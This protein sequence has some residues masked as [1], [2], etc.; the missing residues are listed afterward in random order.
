MALAPDIADFYHRP[1]GMTDPGA[2]DTVLKDAPGDIPG[3]AAY[4]QNLLLH[5]HWAPVYR[6]QLGRERIDETHTRSLAGM[7]ALMQRHDGRPLAFVR[8]L[9]QRMIGNCRHFSVFGAALLR[10]AGFP[11]RARCGFAM[12]FQKD[13]GVDHWVTEYWNGEAWQMIDF[14]IDALQRAQLQLAFDPLDVPR[15]RFLIAGEA[16]QRC[17]TGAADPARFGILD[18]NGLWFVAGNVVR[19]FAALNNREMLPWDVWGPM[20][21]PGQDMPGDT[22]ALLDRLAILCADP[23]AHFDAIRDLYETGPNLKVPPQVFNALRQ[24]SETV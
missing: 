9:D 24:S 12:Y 19:D 18:M 10:R 17:R 1:V 13:F 20:T 3:M 11:A 23:D 6:R 16:W 14:Q 7:L 5:Q 15:D 8:T 4:I 2:L 22:L 21:E